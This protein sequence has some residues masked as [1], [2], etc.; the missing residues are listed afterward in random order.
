MI[1]GYKEGSDITILNTMYHTDKDDKGKYHDYLTLVYRDNQTGKKGHKIIESPDYTYYQIKPEFVQDYNPLFIEMDKVDPIV[2]PYRDITKSIAENHDMLD[3][4]Y[5]NLKSGNSI[6]N[7]KFHTLTDIMNSDGDIEDHYRAKFARLYTN[8]S[9]K[10]KKMFLDIEADTREMAGDFPMPGECP[11]NAVSIFDVNTMSLSVFLLRNK[12]NLQIQDFENSLNN[13]TFSHQK[14]ADFIKENV[15]GRKPY[16]RYKLDQLKFRINFYDDEVELL[17]A[18]FQYIKF[19]DPDFVLAWNMGFDIPYIIA[20]LE[21]LGCDPTEFMCDDDFE[22]KKC[23][24]YIDERNKNFPEERGDRALISSYAVYLDQLIGFASRRKGQSKFDSMKLDDI[25]SV[26]AGVHKLDYSHITTN[27]SLLP[28]LDYIT[29]VLYNMFDVIV[30]YCIEFKTND[31]EYVLNKSLMNSVRYSK[32]HRQSV[33]LINRF[34]ND[35]RNFDNYIIGNNVNKFNP[36]PTEKFPGA[37]VGDPTHNTD[38]AKVRID[39]HPIN[40]ADNGMDYDYKSLYPSIMDEFNIAPN[41][42]YGMVILNRNSYVNDPL[43]YNESLYSTAGRFLENLCSENIITFANRYFE[44]ANY[45]ELIH[46][47]YEYIN[48]YGSYGV[49]RDMNTGLQQALHKSAGARSA[50]RFINDPRDIM[51]SGIINFQQCPNIQQI[52]NELRRGVRL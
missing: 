19:L 5:D 37:L 39:G 20:R 27:I 17:Y 24:Y 44:M 18:L 26:I 25:G 9:F 52:Q 32:V 28:Y 33:Y 48:L 36:K 21:K 47:V 50:L 42:Q 12:N 14:I 41:T 13:G 45:L 10:P 51:T 49:I 29:F 1:T 31:V 3:L 4:Y 2:V 15:G 11:I 46:D 40:I 38:Y 43:K 35:M 16:I 22:V 7:Q 6:E 8:N 34:G 23:R 30:Q